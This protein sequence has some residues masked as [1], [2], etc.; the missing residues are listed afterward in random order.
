VKVRDSAVVSTTN[1]ASASSAASGGR[2]DE[3]CIHLCPVREAI[4]ADCWW[5]AMRYLW[6]GAVSLA[7]CPAPHQAWH[8]V[9]G[10]R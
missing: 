9:T 8:S 10:L 4:P 5:W 2:A 7:L 1:E 3:H 6:Q